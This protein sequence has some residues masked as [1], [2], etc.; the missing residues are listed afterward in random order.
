MLQ[1]TKRRHRRSD[2][3]MLA[4]VLALVGMVGYEQTRP[5]TPTGDVRTYSTLYV[6]SAG[7]GCDRDILTLDYTLTTRQEFFQVAKG[8]APDEALD[9]LLQDITVEFLTPV[10][11]LEHPGD[12]MFLFI[13]TDGDGK[14]DTSLDQR[15]ATATVKGRRIK[16]ENLNQR[17]SVD[18]IPKEG[19]NIQRRLFVTGEGLDLL[20]AENPVDGLTV[21]A[22]N[23]LMNRR[24]VLDV[25]S[26]VDRSVFAFADAATRTLPD[27]IAAYPSFVAGPGV[28]DFVLPAGNHQFEETVIVP[29]GLIGSIEPGAHIQLGGGSSFVSY[30]PIQMVGTTEQPI[31]IGPV[32]DAEPYGSFAMIGGIGN[33]DTI[34]VQNVR[35]TGGS[36]ATVNGAFLSGMFSIHRF[37]RTEVL[38]SEFTGAQADD[39]LNIKYSDVLV[40]GNYFADNSA[41]AI[42]GD[43]VTGMLEDNYFAGN[44]ND[45]LDFSGSDVVVQSNSVRGSGD[46]CVSVGEATQALITHNVFDGCQ[47]GVE[48]KDASSASITENVI[49]NSR[50]WA[51]NAYVKKFFFGVPSF[52]VVNNVLLANVGLFGEL[53]SGL[54]PDQNVT[55]GELD[56]IQEE[57]G[58][59]AET[60]ATAPTR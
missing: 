42:D 9:L 36:E 30:S 35:V 34:R 8:F 3:M 60:L 14:L 51:V 7:I 29:S 55:T 37:G 46:K 45:A 27:F 18:D 58:W 25:A 32:S 40:A 16:F 24:A 6:C 48:V 20:V 26:F 28:N 59:V 50:S 52:D 5:A 47:I 2:F 10:N 31:T 1:S 54:D 39:G 43:F 22:Q 38:A 44:G 23:L 13:D 12:Q 15:L 19:L 4:I 21:E 49:Q 56:E 17:V 11:E 41:D 53:A 33:D 57:L